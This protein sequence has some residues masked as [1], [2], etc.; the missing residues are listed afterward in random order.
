MSPRTIGVSLG[1]MG[2]LYDGLGEFAWQLGTHIAAVAPRWRSELGI[3]FHV[4]CQAKLA[5]CFGPEL[6]YLSVSRWQ[7]WRHLQPVRYAI[8]HSVHQLKRLRRRVN[9]AVKLRLT[10]DEQAL[11]SA[12]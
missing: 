6:R 9:R 1:N 5:G 7:R 4:H 10:N 12:G 11:F 3:E 2:S 8:W